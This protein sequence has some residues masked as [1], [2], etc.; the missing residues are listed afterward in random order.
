MVTEERRCWGLTRL[1]ES[2]EAGNGV[3]IDKRG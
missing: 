3:M 2:G 1:R